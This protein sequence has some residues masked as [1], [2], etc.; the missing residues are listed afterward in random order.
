MDKR[1]Q[2][3]I[4]STFADLEAER[5]SV[6][7]TVMQLDCI[8]AGMELFPAIDDEQWAFIRR[9]IDDCDYY[10]LL[11]AAR[12]G[13]TDTEGLSYTEKEYDYAVEQG[14]KVLAFLHDRPAELR[15]QRGDAE[16]QEL[17]ERLLAFR[18]K[19]S[20]NRLVKF[21]TET[22]ELQGL[23][24][25]SLSKT[26]KAYPAVGWIR[27]DQAPATQILQELNEIRMEKDTLEKELV[28]A[29]GAAI[30]DIPNLAV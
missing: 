11:I 23:V 7:Q 28:A 18:E 20:S 21:W 13:S 25:L 15:V 16:S 19:V 26:I 12:Y 6:I 1:Y 22:S 2:V 9:I 30:P 8:P 3:F 27:A 10:I 17:F 4:S 24:A 14:L 29:R 5:S